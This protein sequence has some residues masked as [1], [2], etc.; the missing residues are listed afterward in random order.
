MDI[1]TSWSLSTYNF[2]DGIINQSS[3]YLS[4]YY[5]LIDFMVKI[6]ERLR[7]NKKLV[8]QLIGT[9]CPGPGTCNRSYLKLLSPGT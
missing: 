7:I 6:V 9:E 4:G 2:K 5:V 1:D 8:T 3:S